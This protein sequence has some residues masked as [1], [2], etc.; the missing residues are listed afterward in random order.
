MCNYGAGHSDLELSGMGS[1]RKYHELCFCGVKPESSE[2]NPVNNDVDIILQCHSVQVTPYGFVDQ[3]VVCI[4]NKASI[5]GEADI[6]QRVHGKDEKE[7]PKDG[8]LRDTRRNT[9]CL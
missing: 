1:S 8:P 3:N 5:D 6:S 4:K 9:C 2:I 7:W